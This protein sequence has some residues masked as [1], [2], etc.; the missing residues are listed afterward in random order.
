MKEW[1]KGILESDT[2]KAIPILSFPGVQLI[3]GTVEEL[4][5]D[6]MKQ[7]QC[8]EAIAKRFPMGA[9]LSLMD[10]S[11]EAE[12][13][14]SAVTYSEEEVPTV[15]GALLSSME[16]AEALVIPEVDKGRPKQCISGIQEA[17][18]R[19]QDRPVFAGIIG[20]FSLAGRLL[21]MTEIMILCYEEPEMV[22]IVLK[23]ATE[24][25]V[26]YAKA[27]KEAGAD[28]IIM[29]EPAAGL[30]SPALMKEFSTPYVQKIM[31]AVED[32]N[33]LVVYHNC[34]NV[35]PLLKNIADIGAKAYSFGNA[36]DIEEALKYLPSDVLVLGNIDPAGVIRQ[37]S[38]KTVYEKTEALLA[39]CSRYP[40][41]VIASGC[42][43]PP[44]SP[45]EN[46]QA[47]FDAVKDF[48]SRQ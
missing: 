18:R 6:G 41:F 39:R 43:I 8:M 27:F 35:V 45:M 14:G 19:I 47:F 22:E 20:P 15:R 33:F 28:G 5:K 30:L 36:I 37:G 34:G 11:V 21:D 48:Y 4:V 32:E 2:K 42:D 16:D 46:I 31:H 26:A 29:A 10:L 12:A 13:F 3:G 23:K 38:P 25:L 44:E 9:S 1:I 24:F 40:N 7:A 17:K